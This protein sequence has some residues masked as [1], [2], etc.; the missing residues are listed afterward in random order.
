MTTVDQLVEDYLG[1]LEEE[2]SDVPR[3]RRRE[4]V[5]EIAEHI[6]EGRAEATTEAEVRTLLDRL[7]EPAEIADEARERFGVPERHTPKLEMAALALIVLGL[8][9][10]IIPWLGAVVWFA[11]VVLVW[12]SDRWSWRDKWMGTLLFGGG[13]LLAALALMTGAPTDTALV[14]HVVL[15]LGA[16]VF[17][18]VRLR[19]A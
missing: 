6:A 2:L 12:M 10:L 11:G 7:G 13:V 15:S 5:G 8:F 4:L 14:C 18:G 9:L 17:L 19:K 16:L 3:A 1:R